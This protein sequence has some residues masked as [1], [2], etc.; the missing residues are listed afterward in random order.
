MTKK[1]WEFSALRFEGEIRTTPEGDAEVAGLVI[2]EKAYLL[3][4]RDFRPTELIRLVHSHGTQGAAA[5]FVAHY[6]AATAVQ[7]NGGRA[8]IAARG[9]FLEPM[10]RRNDEVSEALATG[11]QECANS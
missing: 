5:A 2:S 7:S 8:L 9:H 6:A 4:V 1:I 3:A 11:R 10:I